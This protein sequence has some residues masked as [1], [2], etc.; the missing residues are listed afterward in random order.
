MSKGLFLFFAVLTTFAACSQISPAPAYYPRLTI[1]N[2]NV[3]VAVVER[4]TPSLRQL[5]MFTQQSLT[6]WE[7]T[8]VIVAVSPASPDIDVANGFLLQL[9]TGIILCAYRH[10]S[11]NGTARV[12]R[13][14]VSRSNDDGKT[15]AFAGSVVVGTTGVWEP[16][17][18]QLSGDVDD[19]NTVHVAYAAEITN[20]GEQD[21]VFQTS[22]DGGVTWGGVWS[23]VHTSGSRNGMPGLALLS[24]GS[25][26][27]VFEGFWGTAG[28]GHYTVNSMRSFDHG[29]TWGQPGIVHAPANSSLSNAGSPQVAQCRVSGDITVVFMSSEKAFSSYA[30]PDGAHIGT[31]T[32]HLSGD[33]ASSPLVFPAMA[34]TVTTPT[35]IYWPSLFCDESLTQRIA[36]QSLSGAAELI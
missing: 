25:L 6:S 11:G 20:G 13:V 31:V 7:P 22:R 32:T 33:N 8:S 9:R 3:T 15:W 1:V 18:Y 29:E 10:H 34:G 23:R 24:D 26:F 17:L 2:N 4:P 28:W 35:T 30:W 12:Y 21:I 5:V 16:F 27:L 19:K 14:Q 36:Y